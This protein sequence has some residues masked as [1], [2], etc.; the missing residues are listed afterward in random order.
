MRRG[1]SP[2]P[3]LPRG[4]RRRPPSMPW[5]EAAYARRSCACGL[6]VPGQ[7]DDVAFV[8]PD[9]RRPADA[10][11][12]GRCSRGRVFLAGDS[13]HLVTPAGGKGMNL[14]I[15]DA[16]ELAHGL[17]ERFGQHARRRRLAPYSAT[18]LP[19]SGAPRPSRVD[20][21]ADP[22][23]LR[24]ATVI[25]RRPFGRGPAAR[26]GCPRSTTIP[27]SHVVRPRLRRGRHRRTHSVECTP[28]RRG[29]V[30][31]G[32]ATVA[33]T[34]RDGRTG[35]ARPPHGVGP[36]GLSRRSPSPSGA[37]SASSITPLALRSASLRARRPLGPPCRRPAGCT[38][39]S[40]RPAPARPRPRAHS[41]C[42]R[43][44]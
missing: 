11:A 7:L 37:N 16:V 34:W 1:P 13:A 24:R 3:L 23:R 14:A 44:R 9:A 41:S 43:G 26:A 38:A 20:A 28:Q 36:S 17:V 5:P 39:A 21:A 22:G 33:H 18:R 8:E 6:D 35:T 31:R 32:R 42:D 27:C 10:D 40:R 25:R 4:R 30:A 19:A 15:Q 2:D 12:E 29:T